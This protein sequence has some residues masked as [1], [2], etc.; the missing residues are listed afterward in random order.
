MRSN[1]TRLKRRSSVDDMALIVYGDLCVDIVARAVRLAGSGEESTLESLEV[2]PGG[3]A[4]NCAI[5]AAR[6]GAP[7]VEVI[8]MVGEDEF[9]RL[10][11]E[12]LLEYNVGTS[13]VRV[14]GG[15]RT[16]TVLSLV[17]GAQGERTLYSYRGVNAE[18]YGELPRVDPGDYLY[19][20][21]YSIQDAGSRANALALRSACR[22]G[23]LLDPSFQFA[24]SADSFVLQGL[25]WITPNECEAR[26]LTGC[27]KVED[28]AAAL[29]S[30]GVPNVVVKLGAEGC[31][32]SAA[33]S[34]PFRVPAAGA[35]LPT[36]TTGAG[37]AFCGGFLAAL[38][39][40]RCAREAAEAG[41]RAA[42]LAIGVAK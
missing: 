18:L 16:G 39:A 2:T 11:M 38:M 29:H 35:R 19:L 42:A 13:L 30:R 5:A 10:L 8:G 34:E 15:A 20:S 28:C 33:G 27:A 22:A 31:L 4:L 6:A 14:R 32:V 12:R 36:N 7:K 1:C 37:D 17:S 21:G 9:G 24:G 40:G 41:N 3:A 26:L 23:C 25:D